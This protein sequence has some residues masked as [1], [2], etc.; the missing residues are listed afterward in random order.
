MIDALFYLKLV[1]SAYTGIDILAPERR[2]KI[3]TALLSEKVVFP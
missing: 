2:L 3:R 1:L